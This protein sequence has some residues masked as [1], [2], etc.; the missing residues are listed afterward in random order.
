MRVLV[1]DFGAPER[2][3]PLIPATAIR[4]NG[5]LPGVYVLDEQGRPNLRLVRLGE[6][7]P[8]GMVNVLSGLR[9]GERILGDPPPGVAAGWSGGTAAPPR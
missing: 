4:Y 1:P 8:D 3:N 7:Q 2:G 6:R 5:S 9:P